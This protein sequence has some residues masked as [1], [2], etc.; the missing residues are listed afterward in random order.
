MLETGEYQRVGE[1]ACRTSRARI[2]AATNRDLKREV[3]E[4][5]FRADLY[6]RLSVFTIDAPPLRE[7]GEDKLALLEHFMQGCCAQ[8]GL[9]PF[10][11]D[12]EARAAWLDYAFP[13]NVRELRNIVI[14]LAAKHAGGTVTPAML[15]DELDADL[16]CDVTA[17]PGA[18][19]R[20][21][22]VA[23]ARKHLEAANGFVL[24]D[25]VGEW[26]RAYVTAAL[27]ST[28][29]N[30]TRAARLLGIQR[31]TLYSRMQAYATAAARRNEGAA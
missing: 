10:V 1:T 31:T 2:L 7:L 17:L 24:D 23:M 3:R 25:V 9:R 21:S 22:L 5:R 12:G 13:G 27:A 15:R 14:R 4:G 8:T 28:D 6:H 30:L 16:A 20:E 19:S 26:E 18:S 29:G 11:L